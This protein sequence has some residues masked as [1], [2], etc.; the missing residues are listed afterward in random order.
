MRTK[1]L[2]PNSMAM[3]MEN[4]RR[5]TDDVE[6][7]KDIER[8]YLLHEGHA[9]QETTLSELLEKRDRG[10]ITFVELVELMK[11][12]TNY[13]YEQL[14]KTETEGLTEN[15]IHELFGQK[16]Q[17]KWAKIAAGEEEGAEEGAK[18]SD[19]TLKFRIREKLLTFAYGRVS[20]AL[21]ASYG[22]EKQA[23]GPLENNLKQAQAAIQKGNTKAALK[24]L[25]AGAL[26]ASLK[27]VKMFFKGLLGIV[28][29]IAGV[30]GKIGKL[31]RHPIVRVL[32]LGSAIIALLQVTTISAGVYASYKVANKVTAL[33]TGKSLTGHIVGAA[34]KAAVQ[35]A[36]SAIGLEETE[37]VNEDIEGMMSFAE[38]MDEMGTTEVAAAII[39][40]GEK[41]ENQE[42][43]RYAEDAIYEMEDA[44]G[45][46]ISYDEDYFQYSNEALASEMHAFGIL[47]TVLSKM[48]AGEELTENAGIPPEIGEAM[49]KAL[50]AGKA[51]CLTDEAHCTG[52]EELSKTWELVWDG[53]ISGE[54]TDYIHDGADGVAEWTT[55]M[56]SSIGTQSIQNV[57]G[58]VSPTSWQR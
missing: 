16:R 21:K 22:Q 58:G 13:E 39:S 33:A 25:G 28:K 20:A 46:I 32:L 36:A 8:M 24:L 48:Q 6:N 10:E 37:Q 7:E 12:S 44:E 14:I 27:G 50:E 52:V 26:K 40:L 3:I 4:F 53:H 55:N 23:L 1:P 2:N 35:G 49:V 54:I 15:E 47:K 30:V 51:A 57:A 45:N 29:L 9:P 43:M 11:H 38:V 19:P 17:D 34:G 56:G 41:L 5:Y 31:M 42:V 18:K